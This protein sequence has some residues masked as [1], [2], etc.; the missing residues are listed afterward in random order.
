MDMARKSWHDKIDEPQTPRI[1]ILTK[2]MMGFTVGTRMLISTPREVQAV[3][4]TLPAGRATNSA[5]FRSLL[6]KR[7]GADG[8]CPLTTGIFLRIV[9]EDALRDL[10]AGAPIAAVAPFW[11]VIDPGHALAGKLPG[12]RDRIAELRRAEGICESASA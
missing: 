1:E 4:R 10:D 3:L 8:A 12:G 7:H 11:R 6:A 9:A 5:E 2:P